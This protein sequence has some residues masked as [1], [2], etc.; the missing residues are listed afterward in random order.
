MRGRGGGKEEGNKHVWCVDFPWWPQLNSSHSH[1]LPS[2]PRAFCLHPLLSPPLSSLCTLTS[3][4]VTAVK[5]KKGWQTWR[6]AVC[7]CHHHNLD[8]SSTDLE[9]LPSYLTRLQ[10]SASLLE[11]FLLL[12]HWVRNPALV[13]PGRDSQLL[14]TRK[15][16][17]PACISFFVV[18]MLSWK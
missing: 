16:S 3:A 7:Q 10:F 15:L 13:F 18:W 11:V 9:T 17:F 6:E 14:P 1:C 8:V 2:S 12:P 5:Q 4:S